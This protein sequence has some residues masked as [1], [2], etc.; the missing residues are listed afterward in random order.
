MADL[1]CG[2]WS[3]VTLTAN[4]DLYL[5]GCIDNLQRDPA[6]S[7]KL[8]FPEGVPTKQGSGSS[9]AIRQFSVGRSH[10]LALADDGQIW[11]W[12]GMSQATEPAR[13]V[14]LPQSDVAIR[15]PH[16]G[17]AKSENQPR[18]REREKAVKVVAGWNRSSAYVP[19][20]GIIVWE[21][22]VE[23]LSE[24]ERVS[25]QSPREVLVVQDSYYQRPS[26]NRINNKSQTPLQHRAAMVGKAV[27]WIIL[28]NHVVFVTTTGKVFAA[29]ITCENPLDE[30][31][32][33]L[34]PSSQ[35]H[36]SEDD[37]RPDDSILDVQG[38]HETFALLY[39][40]G[41]VLIAN[42]GYLSHLW[43][44]NHHTEPPTS[45]PTPTLQKIPALQHTGV[46]Q[47]A[48]GD[49]HFHALHSDGT[50]SSY[51]KEPQFCGALG[52]GGDGI[53]AVRGIKGRGFA[54]DGLLLEQCL[55]SGRRVSFEPEKRMWLDYVRNGGGDREEALER[56][57]QTFGDD[58]KRAETSEWF[59]MKLRNWE[60]T[61]LAGEEGQGKGE[62]DDGLPSYFALGVAA[63]GWHSGAIVL[64]NEEKARRTR[65]RFE[66]KRPQTEVSS[67]AEG[68]QSSEAPGILERVRQ[69]VTGPPTEG[70]QEDGGDTDE[71]RWAWEDASHTFPR[72]TLKSGEVMPGR[73]PVE[74]W[75]C[76][77][78]KDVE[79]VEL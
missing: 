78:W 7:Q 61:A 79:H 59:E 46:I 75:Q 26:N 27:N 12:S 63:A 30:E 55:T 72:L 56:M 24:S 6:F 32:F 10:I 5:D 40:T 44:I 31:T 52:L 77:E 68:A 41:K 18:L 2:G 23:L 45:S 28:S 22:L 65:Q 76:P 58:G 74:D 34:R 62:G 42:E 60:T 69:L 66:V 20:N 14:Q 54:G 21:P 51:G 64:V 8:G 70:A 36:Y 29:N 17:A 50:V 19:G 38:S 13:R 11:S 39:R 71:K 48:F 1:Q 16:D 49:W 57:T 43:Q 47:L 53:E 35:Q 3:T 73:V 15:I 4:G 9:T 25:S 67:S 33:E 37:D